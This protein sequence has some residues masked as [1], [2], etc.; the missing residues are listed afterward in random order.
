[1]ELRTYL[2]IILRRKWIIIIIAIVVT[3]AATIISLLSTPK[4]ISTATVRVATIGG[5]GDLTDSSKVDINYS[6]LIMQTY[7]SIL[8]TGT[9]RSEIK[10][11]LGLER[12]PQLD[13]DLVPNT[14]LMKIRAEATDPVVARD[15]ANLGAQKLI[16][17]SQALYSGSGVSSLELLEEEI[18]RVELEL[19]DARTNYDQLI[20]NSPDDAISINAASELIAL[21]ERTQLSLFQQFETVRTEKALLSNQI[22]IIEE[23]FASSNQSSPRH[24]LNIGLGIIMGLVLGTAVALLTENLDNTLHTVHQIETITESPTVG[25]IPKSDEKLKIIKLDNEFQSELE[26]FRRLRTNILAT[27]IRMTNQAILITSAE[28]GDGKSTILANLAVVLAQS[29]RRVLVVDCDLRR[30]SQHDFFGASDKR[31][32]TNVLLGEMVYDDVV[33]TTD[34]PRLDIVT[35]GSLP[36]NPTELLGSPQMAEFLDSIKDEYDMVLLDT[37]ALFSVIDAAVLVPLVE[38]V[39][40]VV[41]KAQSRRDALAAVRQQLRNV[42]AKEISVVINRTEKSKTF[43]Y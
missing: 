29:G 9:V 22:S 31:G 27:D 21:K 36:P 8:T 18:A 14:E 24:E 41:A 15:I 38:S 11:E 30:P 19:E 40:L 32:L 25:R 6:Q 1:M 16:E 3:I 7:A 20:Q 12:F 23:A 26:A 43:A 28:H 39:V 10:E 35:S 34:Y 37:P 13:A 2:N 5:Q 17:Q 42:Q 4:Y 33:Q